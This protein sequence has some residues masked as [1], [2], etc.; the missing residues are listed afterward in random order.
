MNLSTASTRKSAMTARCSSERARVAGGGDA[1]HA[2]LAVAD[3][4][5]EADGEL[6]VPGAGD[7]EGEAFLADA[8]VAVGLGAGEQPEVAG[9]GGGLVGV[10]EGRGG[11]GAGEDVGGA[12]DRRTHGWVR[13][14]AVVEAAGAAWG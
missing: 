7:P 14:P 10:R 4:R 9:G 12:A 13:S 6:A 2:V 1:F 8:R 5:L 3:D 11:W